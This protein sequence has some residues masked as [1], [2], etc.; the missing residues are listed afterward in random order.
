MN[1]YYRCNLQKV[2]FKIHTKL[3]FYG[4]HFAI[5]SILLTCGILVFMN[6]NSFL[7][8]PI[9]GFMALVLMAH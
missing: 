7:L 1:M 9:S 8:F 6:K 4:S 3:Q 5:K 2:G